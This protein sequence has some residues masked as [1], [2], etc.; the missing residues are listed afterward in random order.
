MLVLGRKSGEEIVIG[1]DITVTVLQ[2]HGNRVKLGVA[3]PPAVP[4]HG[5]SFTRESTIRRAG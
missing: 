2:V 5:R 1:R 3:G 4:I